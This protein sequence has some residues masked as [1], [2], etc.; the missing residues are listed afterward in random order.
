MSASDSRN[1]ASLNRRDLLRISAAAGLGLAVSKPDVA[2]ASTKTAVHQETGNCS[3]PRCAIAG[4]SLIPMNR[5]EFWRI[6]WRGHGAAQH[7]TYF[8]VISGPLLNSG[9]AELW[10]V[11]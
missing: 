6:T 8:F 3:R 7:D 9:G 5:R 2:M 4:I 1:G 10:P 11:T